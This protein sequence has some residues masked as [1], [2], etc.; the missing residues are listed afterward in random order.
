MEVY[1]KASTLM[2]VSSKIEIPGRLDCPGWNETVTANP[3][4]KD[5]P[6]GNIYSALA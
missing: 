1:L 4:L 2:G 6:Q 5:Y 3:H